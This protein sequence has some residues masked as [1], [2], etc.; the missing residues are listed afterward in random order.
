MKIQSIVP[1]STAEELG[2]QSGDV[3][4]SING[5][6]IRDVIDY[7]FLVADEFV[8]LE[9]ERAGER[10]VFEVEKD[11]DDTLGLELE[12][13]KIRMC[14]NDC[15]FCFV[16]Q[17]PAGMR[18][19][20]Y[21]RD[22]D[23]RLSFLAGHYVTLTNI[24]KRDLERIVEQKL[25]PLFISVHAVDLEVRRFLLGLRQDDRLLEKL[26]FLTTNG[27]ELHTQIVVCPTHND[28]KVLDETLHKLATYFPQIRSVALVPLGLTKHRE[29][30][31]YLPPV[32]PDYARQLIATA[33]QYA[34]HFKKK[35]DIH[36]VYPADEFYLIAETPLP[37]RSRYDTFDQL[38]N[39]V[40]MVSGLLAEFAASQPN[41]PRALA[42][43]GRA[44]LVTATLM[45]PV[46]QQH[47]VPALNRTRNFSADLVAVPNDFY[48][49]TIHVTG[50]LTGRDIHKHLRG[51]DN[52]DLV[53]LPQNCV[54]GDG[55]F[56]DDWSLAQL[57][58][59]LGVPVRTLSN[60]FAA[61]FDLL[62]EHEPAA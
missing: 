28:G 7:R 10:T 29:G 55:L 33:D 18:Q 57:E 23:F 4:H 3:L 50:L 1:G 14:G 62:Q 54:N 15:P 51:R 8:E 39:G 36:F 42:K 26:D 61:I 2:L 59:Q 20:L 12:P 37:S 24:S 58:A 17:N 46:L 30:L 40:G 41:L 49:P 32:T 56:L 47:I 27:I 35:L 21:F 52:G 60:D 31:T 25:S 13:I 38:E 34:A 9:V 43:P 16:D 53:V 5:R 48:G 6:R 19:T 11:A 45:A 44:T 22:E